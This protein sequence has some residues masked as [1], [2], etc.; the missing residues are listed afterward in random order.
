MVGGEEVGRGGR[1]R[2][3]FEVEMV[4]VWEVGRGEMVFT[5]GRS[6][7]AVFDF[8]ANLWGRGEIR[9]RGEK[10]KKKKKKVFWCCEKHRKERITLCAISRGVAW[11]DTSTK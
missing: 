8:E 2:D 7:E 4:F 5:G 10:K 3:V 11:G 9:R 6:C 1:E